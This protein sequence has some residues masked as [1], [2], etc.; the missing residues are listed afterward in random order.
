MT[1]HAALQIIQAQRAP[2]H[3]PQQ[4][5]YWWIPVLNETYA[6]TKRQGGDVAVSLHLTGAAAVGIFSAGRLSQSQLVMSSSLDSRVGS[7]MGGR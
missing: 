1:L 6:T 7:M 4:G 3:S 2:A 5:R